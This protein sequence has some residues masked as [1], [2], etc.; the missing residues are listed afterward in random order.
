MCWTTKMLKTNCLESINCGGR[1][2]R[3]QHANAA[4][5]EGDCFVHCCISPVSDRPFFAFL[6][7]FGPSLCGWQ[8]QGHTASPYYFAAAIFLTARVSNAKTDQIAHIC[9][10]EGSRVEGPLSFV[11]NDC[12]EEPIW[13]GQP[14]YAHPDVW[15]TNRMSIDD[16]MG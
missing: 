10:P 3:A 7:P 14:C 15:P 2:S 13:L 6:T 4:R 5:I 9:S 1:F 12:Q 16:V 8:V 11:K